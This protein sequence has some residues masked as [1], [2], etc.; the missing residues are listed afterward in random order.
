M[1]VAAEGVGGEVLK[2]S[3]STGRKGEACRISLFSK[4][5]RALKILAIGSC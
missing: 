2:E 3:N 4:E 5:E 1:G